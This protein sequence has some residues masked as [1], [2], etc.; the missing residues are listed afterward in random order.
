VLAAI[1]FVLKLAE[2]EAK[3]TATRSAT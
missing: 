1:P 3:G 2:A